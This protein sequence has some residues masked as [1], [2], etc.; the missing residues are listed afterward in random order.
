MGEDG[1]SG[2]RVHNETY[3]VALEQASRLDFDST[4]DGFGS[5]IW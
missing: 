1:G 3:I 5:G 2:W 4:W